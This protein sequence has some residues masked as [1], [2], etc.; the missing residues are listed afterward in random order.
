MSTVTDPSLRPAGEVLDRLLI[1][2]ALQAYALACDTRDA[3][4]L[5]ALFTEDARAKYDADPWLSGGR[6]IVDWI[7]FA[8]EGVVHSQHT[9]TP[10]R[11]AVD[12]AT[13]T[14]IAYLTSGQ[15]LEHAPDELVMMNSRYDFALSRKPHGWRI[16]RLVLEVGW[17]E[18]RHFAQPRDGIRTVPSGDA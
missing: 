6:Q 15:R 11:I 14:A 1:A 12:G 9:L 5:L 13:A 17:F 3:D 4:A 16:S 10:V 7:L 18:K 8:T 2:E